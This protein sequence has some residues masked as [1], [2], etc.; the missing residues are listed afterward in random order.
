MAARELMRDFGSGLREARVWIAAQFVGFPLLALA[1]IGWTRLPEKHAWQV[2]LVLVIPLVLVAAALALKAGLVR[3]MMAPSE[4]RV[5]LVWGALA[6]LVWMILAWFVW[7]LLDRYDDHIWQYAAYLNSKAPAWWRG[8]LFTFAHISAWL[9]H[10]EWLLRWVV[11][12]SIVVPLGVSS[13]VRGWRLHWR[14]TLHVIHDWRW[15]FAVLALAL[16]G[17]GL[18]GHFFS[19]A[20]H[21]S[22]SAQVWAVAL[23]LVGAYLIGFFCWIVL[24]AWVCALLR[25]KEAAKAQ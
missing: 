10:V 13:A 19:G 12:P 16:V 21:G 7:S 14:S 6:L 25:S 4:G 18:T 3:R 24:L 2:A 23:K 5:R 1:G 17:V 22:L 9:T 8:R 20:P 11:M 15:F